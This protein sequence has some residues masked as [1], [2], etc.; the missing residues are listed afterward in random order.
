MEEREK[1]AGKLR[2]RW[3]GKMTL[4]AGAASLLALFAGAN[5]D[6]NAV[7]SVGCMAGSLCYLAAFVEEVRK[8][9]AAALAE[10]GEGKGR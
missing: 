6:A 7:M 1:S 4:C 9:E 10:G 2:W 8:A 3:S 5:C